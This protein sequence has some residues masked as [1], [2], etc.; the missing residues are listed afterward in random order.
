MKEGWKIKKLGEIC[1]VAPSKNRSKAKNIDPLSEVSFIPMEDLTIG[2]KYVY[3]S[4][5]ESYKNISSGYTYFE[6]GDILIAKVTPCFENGKLA[7][8]KGLAHGIGFG[9]SEY[10]VIRNTAQEIISDYIYYYL[11]TEVFKRNGK[12][13]MVGACGLKRLP[14]AYVAS[15]LIPFPLSFQEQQRIV[16]ILD[17][18]FAKIDALKANAEKSL[19]AAKDLFQSALK[20]ALEPKSDWNVYKLKD[21]CKEYGD[22]GMSVPS[23]P[24]KDIRYL[25]ITDITEWGELNDD[26]VSADTNSIDD[27][28]LLQEGDVLFA[29]TGATVGKSLVYKSTMGRCSYAGYLIRYRLNQD[30]I[31]PQLLFYITHSKSYYDWIRANQKSTTLPNISAKIYNEYEISIPSSLINQ[32]NI[33]TQLDNL[34]ERCKAL[35]ENY[36]KTIALCEDLK[37]A[38]LRKAFNGEL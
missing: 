34:D 33:T 22:Y 5:R 30:M 6:E 12:K 3:P 19:Q 35:Q 29:R 13:L 9:S 26:K 16:E 11:R 28:Y 10:I 20:Q 24:Y 38:L 37:Q 1:E 32:K 31:L 27:K 23:K 14:K 36:R 15:L 18:E 2:D 17:A 7:I 21:V 4:R 8:A 25:R